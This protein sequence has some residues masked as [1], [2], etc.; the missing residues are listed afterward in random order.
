M[1]VLM[2]DFQG[3]SVDLVLYLP[4]ICT[5]RSI[6]LALDENAKLLGHDV[7]LRQRNDGSRKWRNICQRR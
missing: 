6:L 1:F 4:E 5:S 2:L 3:E 7:N